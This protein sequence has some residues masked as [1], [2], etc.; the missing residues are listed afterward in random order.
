MVGL[1]LVLQ[2]GLVEGEEDEG[3]RWYL[4]HE[5]VRVSSDRF[6]LF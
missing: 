4:L 1:L 5:S 2:P 3:D 6:C